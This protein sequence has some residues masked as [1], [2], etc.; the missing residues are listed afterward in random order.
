MKRLI[1]L[2]TLLLCA[3]APATVTTSGVDPFVAAA[4]AEQTA[5]A[6][7]D[8]ADFYSRQLTATAEAPMVAITQTSAALAMVQTQNAYQYTSTAMAWTPTPVPT[9][10]PNAAATLI[11]ANAQAQSTELV[12]EAHLS[13]LQ[14][15]RARITNTAR[16]MSAYVFGFIF[17]LVGVM[18]AITFAKR[19]AVIPNPTNEQG[20]PLPMM[21]VVEGVAFDMDRAVNGV[22]SVKKA[23]L[24]SLPVITTDR[25]DAVTNRAQLVD[26]KTR[27]SVKSAAVMKLLED[28]GLQKQLPAPEA[29]AVADGDL[30]RADFPLPAWEIAQGWDSK[31]GIP[32]GIHSR[33][34]GLM[35]LNKSPHQGAFGRTGSGKSRRFLR[36][37]ITFALAAGHR[38]IILGKQVDFLPFSSHPNAYII[39]VRE[40]TIE[41]EAMKYALFLKALVDE[42]NKRD[43]YLSTHHKSTW[44]QAGRETT[45]VVLDEY[46][47]AMDL[48]P[49]QYADS[50]RRYVKGLL[51]EGRK[52]GFSALI[53]AQRAVGLRDEVTQL[54]RAVFQVSDTQESRFA[55][56]VPGAESLREGYFMAKFA[57]MNMAGAFE[58]TDAEIASFLGG[59]QVANLE[60]QN[61]LEANLTEPEAPA[62]PADEVPTEDFDLTE[63]NIQ[64]VVQMIK[65]DLSI[66]SIIRTVWNV[67]GGSKY[68][69]LSDKV[70]Y[71]KETL[72]GAV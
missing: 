59:R 21:D 64:K 58:P 10:T 54:G 61:W 65:E 66:S 31:D 39:P 62:I 56:G 51:R 71:L 45:V 46:T 19:F 32:Y 34:L 28:H 63:E 55:L 43:A 8:E 24:K 20:K 22:V 67:S 6:A 38:V 30:F 40:L 37:F 69:R 27:T 26:M 9:A 4:R 16:A 47:N 12:N 70:K 23:F 60:P 17:L 33:G 1:I 29:S 72:E 42:M 14:V 49:R 13:D 7:L 18:F 25:Q 44:A 48:M 5:A 3:C 35:D 57:D 11:M 52:Y 53:S 68:L 50:S 2:V 15:E 41:T 36:P